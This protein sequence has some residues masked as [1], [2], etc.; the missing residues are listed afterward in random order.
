MPLCGFRMLGRVCCWFIVKCYERMFSM[1]SR[2]TAVGLW[3]CWMSHCMISAKFGRRVVRRPLLDD[4]MALL[5]GENVIWKDTEASHLV[6]KWL[7]VNQRKKTLDVPWELVAFACENFRDYSFAETNDG[8]LSIGY[9]K[10]TWLILPVVIRSSQRLSHACLSIT[11]LL[12]KL[13][14]AHYISYSF[15]DSP[16][17]LGY[18]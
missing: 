18:P 10:A 4:R 8:E 15:F 3:P 16:L 5:P 2:K 1:N 17:L 9:V 13:R 14:T 11:L 7:N 6:T 12:W